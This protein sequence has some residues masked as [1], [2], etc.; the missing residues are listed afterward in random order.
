MFN[1]KIKN[2]K[3]FTLIETLVSLLIFSVSIVALIS[4]T[5]D[6]VADTNFA[7]KKQGAY[8]LAQ[9]GVELV[10]FYRD[11]A[12]RF[13]TT[14]WESFILF[15]GYSNNN[16]TLCFS[17]GGCTIDAHSIAQDLNGDITMCDPNGCP[18]LSINATNGFYEY[19]TDPESIY[20]RKITMEWISDKEV[21]V[22]VTV[23]W[24][25]GGDTFDMVLGEVLTSWVRK[26]P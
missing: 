2:N 13:G 12:L 24:E 21:R 17:A 10:R 7:K 1:F 22:S 25:H 11:T 8:L 26:L 9:E 23:S 5:A 16:P 20:N 4:I 19:S 18:N 6:G 3:G 15:M 14:D